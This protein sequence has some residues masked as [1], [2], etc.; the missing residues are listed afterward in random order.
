MKIIAGMHRSGTSLVA[1]IAY[2]AGADMGDPSTFYR[3]DRWNPD[4]YFEQPEI[5]AINIPLV[6]GPLWKFSYFFLPSENTIRRRARDRSLAEMIREADSR[7]RNK[8]VKE[9]RFCLTLPA[10]LDQGTEI[11][12]ILLV[13]RNPNEVALS[14]RRRQRV[15]LRKGRTLWE[16]HNRRLLD[17]AGRHQIPMHITRYDR[18]LDPETR[19]EESASAL[20]FLGIDL[21]EDRIDDLIIRVADTGMRHHT[22]EGEHMKPESVRELWEDLVQRHASQSRNSTVSSPTQ[23]QGPE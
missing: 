6:N 4:G 20:A 9:N 22:G 21:A 12:Q 23:E 17:T 19:H 16:T 8:L 2:E 11:E 14:L 10:W 3:P 13:L 18:F 5:H 7:Y 1:R 15:P